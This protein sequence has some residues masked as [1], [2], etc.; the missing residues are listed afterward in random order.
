MSLLDQTPCHIYYYCLPLS[1]CF[2]I[3]HSDQ[4]VSIFSNVSTFYQLS[5]YAW[6]RD[7]WNYNMGT[8]WRSC[9]FCLQNYTYL[10]S[11][12]ML[13][14]L[15]SFTFGL[16]FARK[17]MVG[18]PACVFPDVYSVVTTSLIELSFFCSQ[19]PNIRTIVIYLIV[20][21]GQFLDCALGSLMC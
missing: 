14:F 20:L 17:N 18:N 5:T 7:K 11:Q 12:P 8:L 21:L 6:F 4:N 10:P 9:S 3:P 16:S 15:S 1:A 13:L 19:I 2:S